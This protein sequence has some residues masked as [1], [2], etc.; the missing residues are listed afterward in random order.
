[1]LGLRQ[2]IRMKTL[3]YSRLSKFMSGRIIIRYHEGASTDEYIGLAKG[4]A[5]TAKTGRSFSRDKKVISI[6]VSTE[7]MVRIPNPVAF[8]DFETNHSIS[9]I[10]EKIPGYVVS[11]RGPLLVTRKS[12]RLII[13]SD[14]DVL[15]IS[16][17]DPLSIRMRDLEKALEEKT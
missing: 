1:M 8:D 5:I 13:N 3:R 11:L 12:G 9:T 14:K 16:L 7:W 2:R 15:K 4:G 17:F 10:G 6:T